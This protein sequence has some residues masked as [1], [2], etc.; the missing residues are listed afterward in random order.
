[1]L[2]LNDFYDDQILL[3]QVKRAQRSAGLE[4]EDDDDTADLERRGGRA[5]EVDDEGESQAI[6]LQGTR[7]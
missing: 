1:M 5:E 2:E 6:K 3:R 4:M 7:G